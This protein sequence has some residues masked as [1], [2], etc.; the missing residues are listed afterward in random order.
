MEADVSD[1]DMERL[2]AIMARLRDPTES[3]PWDREQDFARWQ[4]SWGTSCSRA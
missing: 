2:L 3:C 4:K 1:P